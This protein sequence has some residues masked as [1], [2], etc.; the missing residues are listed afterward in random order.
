MT[1]TNSKRAV[2]VA[3]FNT[4]L[5]SLDKV[6]AKAFRQTVLARIEAD[7]ESSRASAAAMYNYA[8]KQAVSAGKVAEFGRAAV[9][10]AAP[11][12][13]VVDNNPWAVVDADG[14]VVATYESRA[15]ARAAKGEGQRVVAR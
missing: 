4:N 5:R 9:A 2:A 7:T 14:A 15:K 1:N 11:V 8:K 12:V 10:K 3:I 13:V 6:G